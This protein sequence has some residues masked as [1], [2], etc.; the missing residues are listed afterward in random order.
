MLIYISN[1]LLFLPLLPS[2]APSHVPSPLIS[3]SHTAGLVEFSGYC[4][5]RC[6]ENYFSR[7]GQC[8]ACDGPCPTGE[9]VLCSHGIHISSERGDHIYMVTLNFRSSWRPYIYAHDL[10]LFFCFFCFFPENQKSFYIYNTR[11]D[12]L[13]LRIYNIIYIKQNCRSNMVY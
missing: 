7:E 1:I 4:I 12:L 9:R 13:G 5:L 11:K 10:F 2:H 6:P 3:P 8:I